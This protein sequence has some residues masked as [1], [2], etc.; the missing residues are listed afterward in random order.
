[1]SLTITRRTNAHGTNLADKEQPVIEVTWPGGSMLMGRWSML[2]L[3]E[4]AIT[5]D[6]A[7]DEQIRRALA[8]DENVFDYREGR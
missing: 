6:K 3:P 8:T 1:M 5:A 2:C 4:G 7:T